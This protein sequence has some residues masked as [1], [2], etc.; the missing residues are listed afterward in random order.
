LQQA[1]LA[2]ELAHN[3]DRRARRHDANQLHQVRVLKPPVTI[4]ITAVSKSIWYFINNKKRLGFATRT[5]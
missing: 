5:S 3:H 2:H 1:A 4:K